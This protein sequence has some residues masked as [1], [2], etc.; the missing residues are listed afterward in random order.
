MNWIDEYPHKLYTNV[1]LLD[2][3]I[4]CWKTGNTKTYENYWPF[5]ARW[6]SDRMSTTD[7][8]GY[9]QM[10]LGD[11]T[12]ETK[13][14]VVNNSQE[15]KDVFE[16]NSKEWYRQWEHADDYKLGRAYE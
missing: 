15:H 8:H 5:K 1:L 11:Y 2:G 9:V 3:K 12:I 7:K 14:W 13:T 10:G 6:K 16:I 4:E